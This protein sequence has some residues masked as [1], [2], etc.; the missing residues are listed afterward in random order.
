[1]KNIKTIPRWGRAALLLAATGL[2]L[3]C[4]NARSPQ[5]VPPTVPANPV[6]NTAAAGDT[7]REHSSEEK[8]PR[9]NAAEAKQQV[10]AGQAVIID[11]R[12]SKAYQQ[13]HIKGALDIHL[14]DLEAGK[15]DKLPK[16]KRII[17]Y[18]T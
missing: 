5:P 13:T 16:D 7:H 12:G 14:A 15:F 11:V 6:A 18:C 1:M 8:M 9:V 3:A 2:A 10:D 17:A 4:N